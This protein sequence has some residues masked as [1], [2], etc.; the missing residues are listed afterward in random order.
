MI[1]EQ[2]RQHDHIGPVLALDTSTAAMAAAIVR[3]KES[4]GEVQ[5]MAE[6]NHSVHVVNHVHKLLKQCGIKQ[7]DLGAIAVGKGPGSYTG[8]RIAASVAK[9]MAWVLNKPL[10]SVSSLEAIAYGAWQRGIEE[11]ICER[12]GLHWVLPIMDA[13]RGQVYT[14]AYS[15]EASDS[16]S[17]LAEDGVRL[18]KDWVDR[19]SEQM[20]D[21]TVSQP[22]CIWLVG[23]LALHM[24]EAERLR[25]WGEE[26]GVSV[27]LYPFVQ[28]G[29]WIGLLGLE[30]LAAGQLE[31]THTFAPNYTQLTEAEVKLKAKQAGEGPR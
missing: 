1:N 8:M 14:G 18:M 3:G 6:R 31:N 17:C 20:K 2:D 26:A 4:L 9:T 10:V 13:R 19:I 11:G 27:L 28:E 15:M 5:S 23:D 29:R 21:E 22:R 25:Q 7:E 16:W 24:K 30:R 12:D